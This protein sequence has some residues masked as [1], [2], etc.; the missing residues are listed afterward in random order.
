MNKICLQCNNEFIVKIS[1]LGKYCSRKCHDK[2][3][4]FNDNDINES[5]K[6]R[7]HLNSKLNETNGCVEWQKYKNS[8]GYGK[9]MI[10]KGKPLLTH[11][12]SWIVSNGEIPIDKLILHSCDNPSCINILHLFIGT[13][14]QN[15]EDMMRKGRHKKVYTKN[16]RPLIYPGSKLSL[17]QVKKIKGL[18]I[19]GLT[20]REIS[21]ITESSI[22]S[23]NDIRRNKTW[24]HWD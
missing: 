15:T 13:A 4:K 6:K 18:L 5:I 7:L 9:I 12:A 1:T 3:R 16:N 19:T 20:S 10:S 22:S 14:S 17:D 21:K 24:K 8:K 23:V 11:R 2:D